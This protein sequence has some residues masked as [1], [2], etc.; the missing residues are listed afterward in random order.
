MRLAPPELIEAM[1]S[2]APSGQL[3]VAP[4]SFYGI[5]PPP[6]TPAQKKLRDQA[7]ANPLSM[8]G[9]GPCPS[10]AACSVLQTEGPLL[11]IAQSGPSL[12]PA[13]MA[14]K[15]SLRM[16]K[17]TPDYQPIHREVPVEQVEDI[18]RVMEKRE[19]GSSIAADYVTAQEEIETKNPYQTD[20]VLYTPQ[21]RRTFHR[22][23]EDNYGEVFHLSPEVK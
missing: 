6:I 15:K 21:S 7:R 2:P 23:I 17:A 13:P 1:K 14:K 11:S 19:D 20:T 12:P 3:D 18:Q 5:P 4:Q 22:F 9:M 10:G 16:I 8:P